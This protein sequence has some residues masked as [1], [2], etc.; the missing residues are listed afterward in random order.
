[1][2]SV[3]SSAS[4]IFF[5]WSIFNI[6]YYTTEYSKEGIFA[7][8]HIQLWLE[9]DNYS[10]CNIGFVDGIDQYPIRGTFNVTGIN[11]KT[12]IFKKI[13]NNNISKI[14]CLVSFNHGCQKVRE[15]KCYCLPTSVE[16]VYEV[17]YNFALEYYESNV[18]IQAYL[19][20]F[21][22][23]TLNSLTSNEVVLPPFLKRDFEN[24]YHLEIHD[25]P[26]DLAQ[27]NF[28]TSDRDIKIDSLVIS[29]LHLPIQLTI[30]E[31]NVTTAFNGTEIS[32]IYRLRNNH[33]NVTFNYFQCDRNI[34]NIVC[35]YSQEPV[36]RSSFKYIS[37]ICAGISVAVLI[38]I[39]IVVL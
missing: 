1:M 16:D 23:N 32:S 2:S 20:L 14:E 4:V 17:F 31:S 27:C 12:I 24:S 25:Q 10:K 26:I 15:L 8:N 18:R 35:T 9:E 7:N 6:I 28:T 33:G 37:G 5:T 38:L 21:N 39:V 29:T 13:D 3:M 22:P 36:V 11:L 34:K 19:M 30:E